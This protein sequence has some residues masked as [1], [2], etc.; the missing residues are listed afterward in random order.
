MFIVTYICN[1][2]NLHIWR[3]V[4]VCVTLCVYGTLYFIVPSRQN[5]HSRDS[6]RNG[7]NHSSKLSY[8]LAI[9]SNSRVSNVL[10]YFRKGTAGF[11]LR[12]TP[13]WSKTCM[14]DMGKV[15]SRQYTLQSLVEYLL[16]DL[17]RL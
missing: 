4:P 17:H 16:H 13:N 7:G 10:G 6:S 15:N 11:L 2:K 3:C 9:L 5:A 8:F 1:L 12:F 14:C